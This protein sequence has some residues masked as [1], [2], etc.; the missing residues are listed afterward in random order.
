MRVTNRT[1]LSIAEFDEIKS[2]L[3]E[4]ENL[5]QAM[6]WALGDQSGAFMPGVV[7]QVIVQDEFS[8]DVVIPWRNGLTLVYATT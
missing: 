5:Q 3:P 6:A 8:H 4:H 7:S 2:D 1:T